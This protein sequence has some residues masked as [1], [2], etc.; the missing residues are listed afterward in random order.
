VFDSP[1]TEYLNETSK[2]ASVFYF[3]T[4]NFALPALNFFSSSKTSVTSL[5]L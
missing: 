3:K 2:L 1:V 4:F 5:L